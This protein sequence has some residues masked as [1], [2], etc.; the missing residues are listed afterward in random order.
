MTDI[1]IKA[2]EKIEELLNNIYHTL[3]RHPLISD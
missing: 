1:E 3:S 2:E